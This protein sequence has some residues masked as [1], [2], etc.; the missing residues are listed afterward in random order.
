M[1]WIV[2]PLV[3]AGML[4]VAFLPASAQEGWQ[5]TSWDTRITISEDGS[6]RFVETLTVDFGS[7]AKHGIFRDL[8]TRVRCGE[9]GEGPAPLYECPAGSDRLYPVSVVAITNGS[10]EPWPYERLEA[11]AN[12]RL[13]I[14]DPNK[15]IS[16]V[17]VYRIEYVVQGALNAFEGHD[18]LYW[19]VTGSEWEVPIE[20]VRVDVA[21]PVRAEVFVACFQGRASTAACDVTASGSDATFASTRTL[22]PGEELTI[23]AGWQKGV[24][25]VQPPVLEDRTSIDD[26]F[27][28]DW[29]E[30]G[31]ASLVLAL[32]LLGA[33]RLWWLHGRDRRY[34]SIYYLTEDPDEETAALFT[35]HQVVVEFLPP[36]DLRPAQMGVI[37]DER[38]DTLDVTATIIDLGV[39]GYMHIAEI[40]KEGWFGKTDWELQRKKEPDGSLLPYESRLMKALFRGREKVKVSKLKT[41]FAEDLAKVKQD[42]YADAMQHR[43]FARNPEHARRT[44]IAAGAGVVVLGIALC[45]LAGLIIERALVPVGVVLFGLLLLALSPAMA[46]RTATGS[47]A[48]RRVLGFKLY[49]TTAETRRQEF[50]EQA[51]IFARYLPYAIVF[52]CVDKWAEAFEGLDDQV[53]DSTTSWYSGTRAFQIGAFS[54]GLSSFSSNVSTAISSTPGGSG[55]SGFSG[56]GSSGGGG[57]GGGGGSW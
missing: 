13:K 2:A 47:E 6:A 31:G 28:F 50:N 23:A 12:T 46:K 52:E 16:G 7:L 10:G 38:A 29:I 34:R 22:F 4:A 42:L 26:F 27:T 32:G 48:L 33:S 11:G 53:A 54:A 9:V 40:P 24:V 21:L 18:E 44:W 14:G 37:V 41:K 25:D 3:V 43:W 8:R 1:R 5:V 19:N 51:N 39:R 55:G 17:Q 49:I 35:K 20:T 45:V 57:G 30:L 15:T 56:G 36:E